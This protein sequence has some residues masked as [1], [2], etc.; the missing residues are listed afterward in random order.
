MVARDPSNAQQERPALI[1]AR[2]PMPPTDGKTKLRPQ[3]HGRRGAPPRARINDREGETGSPTPHRGNRLSLSDSTTQPP[4]QAHVLEHRDDRDRIGGS[5]SARH[6]TPRR[7][8][9]TAQP[10]NNFIDETRQIRRDHGA[11]TSTKVGSVPDPCANSRQRRLIAASNRSG[12][13]M[14]LEMKITPR[15]AARYSRAR[16]QNHRDHPIQP[17]RAATTMR[18]WRSTMQ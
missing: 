3:L 14:M 12:G 10:D 13:R 7:R 11:P 2:T 9:Q 1:A 8:G 6:K 4:M 15:S 18:T 5:R 17:Y 16:T